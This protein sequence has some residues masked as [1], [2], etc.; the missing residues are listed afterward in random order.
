MNKQRAME[1][2]N[3]AVFYQIYPQSFYDSNADGIGDLEGIIQKLDYL[4]WLGV[5]ALWLNPCFVSPFQDAGYDVADYY[6]VA[7]RYG[8]N[9]D[10]K[11]LFNEAHRRGIRVC[12]DLVPGHTSIEHPWF[13]ASCRHERNEFSDRYIWSNSTW[14]RVEDKMK[15]ILGYAERDGAYATNFFYCQPALNYGYAQP[16]PKQPWQQPVTAPGPQATRKELY[17]IMAFWLDLGADGFRV[18]MA[19]SLIKNDPDKTEITRLWREVRQWLDRDYPHAALIAEWGYPRLA[20][21]AGFHVDFM[22]HFNAPG[23][24]SLFF[25]EHGFLKGKNPFFDARGQGTVTEFIGEYLK[26]AVECQDGYISIP[27]ANHDYQRPSAGRTQ[28]ELKV[29]FTFLLTFPGVPFI[30]YGDEIGMRYIEGLPSKEGGYARTGSRT[31]MQWDNSVNAG[32]SR[33][34]SDRLYLPIDP[35]PSRPT[36]EAQKQQPD[37]LLHHVQQLIALRKRYPALQGNGQLAIVYAKPYQYPFVYLRAM[38]DQRFLV[39]VHPADRAIDVTIPVE[40][41]S[42]AE[43]LIGNTSIEIAGKNSVRIKMDGISSAVFKL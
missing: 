35:D 22:F 38:E 19:E 4:S 36:V 34:E 29:I 14:D 32:F 33:A 8:T 12:L 15:F 25:N 42:Q 23:Y 3:Q 18:D 2:L 30:Y 6:Q 7:P 27:S 20:I 41:F 31:P 39:V 13:K 37:S 26:H 16:D 40:N 1:W 9:E 28:S 10:L 11:R 5:N 24:P 43:P 17:K 21:P